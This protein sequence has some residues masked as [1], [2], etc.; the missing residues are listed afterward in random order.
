MR[1]EIMH[2]REKTGRPLVSQYIIPND[3]V[4]VGRKEDEESHLENVFQR[5]Y[6]HQK[7]CFALAL[8]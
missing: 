6:T 5:Y 2:Q 4:D 8:D 7:K 1:C 3:L